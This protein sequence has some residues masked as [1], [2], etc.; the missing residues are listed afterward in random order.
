[1]STRSLGSAAYP[2]P[3]GLQV[4]PQVPGQIPALEVVPEKTARRFRRWAFLFIAWASLTAVVCATGERMIT[5]TLIKVWDSFLGSHDD[6]TLRS[7]ASPHMRAQTAHALLQRLKTKPTAE[8]EHA[9]RV[10]VDWFTRNGNALDASLSDAMG[11]V[12]PYGFAYSYGTKPF[13]RSSLTQAEI[14]SLMLD[15]DEALGGTRYRD[16]ALRALQPLFVDI[17]SGGVRIAETA[18]SNRPAWWYEEFADDNVTPPRVLNG[19]LYTLVYVHSVWQRTGDEGAHQLFDNGM[20]A[21]KNH[22]ADYDTGDW[23][24]YDA[25]GYLAS[26]EYHRV[27]VKLLG[28]L[29]AATGDTALNSL[30]QKWQ[31]YGG[32]FWKR[33]YSN[34]RV[35]RLNNSQIGVLGAAGLVSLLMVLTAAWGM[36]R[37]QRGEQRLGGEMSNSA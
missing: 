37:R 14:A 8:N 20:R 5:T 10:A 36:G 19:M 32:G 31:A 1:M 21:L 26:P 9:A 27:H 24:Y 25:N 30:R 15:A 29:Y 33:F 3:R 7:E 6:E 12:W 35:G 23:T 34:L 17:K 11:S 22:L 2:G 16:W 28:K 18:D 13:W 4:T